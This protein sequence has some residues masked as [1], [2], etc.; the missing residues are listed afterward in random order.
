MFPVLGLSV[1]ADLLGLAAW[2]STID[3]FVEYAR[4]KKGTQ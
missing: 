3:A 4:E 1:C 2:P